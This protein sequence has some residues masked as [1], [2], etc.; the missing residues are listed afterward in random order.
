MIPKIIHGTWRNLSDMPQAWLENIETTKINN[1]DWKYR[2]YS[3]DD[4]MDFIKDFYGNGMLKIYR[5]IDPFYGAARADLFRYLVLYKY[6]GVYLDIKSRIDRSLEL[7]EDDQFLLSFWNQNKYPGAGFPGATFW[8]GFLKETGE[9]QQWC[10]ICAPRHKYLE[11][12]IEKVLA[13][14]QSGMECQGLFGVLSLTGPIVYSETIQK[15][16][17]ENICRLVDF[18]EDLGIVYNPH[19]RYAHHNF[20]SDG[21]YS[22]SN[23]KVL[24]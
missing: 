18:E 23:R 13:N 4:C 24:C 11:L 16:Y 7:Q 21:H 19:G 6:G 1:P 14:I 17:N 20:C 9:F 15:N 8:T 12:V 5:K 3:N 22:Q 10:I 2:F